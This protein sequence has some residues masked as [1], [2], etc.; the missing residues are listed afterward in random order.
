MSAPDVLVLAQAFKETLSAG[1]VGEAITRGVREAGHEPRV[2]LGSDG[3]DGLLEALHGTLTNV[4]TARVP[5][6]LGLPV[7][8]PVGW[9]NPTTAVLESRL[10]CGLSLLP[11]DQRNPLRATTE[12]VG[13]ATLRAVQQGARRVYVG[14]GGS[15]T[16]DGG[17]GFGRALGWQFL[18]ERGKPVSLGGA[19]LEQLVSARP[20]APPGA[21]L[22]GL[23]DVGNRLLGAAGARVFAAQ[24]GAT[25]EEETRLAGG[26][27]RMV[28]VLGVDGA[29]H[30]ELEGAGAA[31]G[32]GF[33]LVHF[34]GGRLEPGARWVLDRVSFDVA[35]AD[36]SCL[37]VCEGGFDGTSLGGKLVGEG[38]SRAA[39]A[40]VPVVLLAPVVVGA[41][42]AGAVVE[43][44]GGTW[45][46]S[47]LAARACAGLRR[48]L[49]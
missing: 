36:A 22:V 45:D 41:V 20:A 7:R 26:L 31:G 23:C 17:L 38:I 37:V 5:G 49:R 30:A 39:R 47:T 18:D 33:G 14:L 8:G 19:G 42:P 9:L 48:A 15:A 4:T 3:G 28:A 44:G 6:P 12:G 34:G 13:V 43:T 21:H 1:E 46:A 40:G 2:L 35:L 27:E 10:I 11:H 24:K 16:M 29:G 25:A 32:L